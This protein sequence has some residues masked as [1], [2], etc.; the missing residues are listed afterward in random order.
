MIEAG[1]NCV[2]QI[3]A[4][5]A[6]KIKKITWSLSHQLA[7]SYKKSALGPWSLKF[8]GG[9]SKALSIVE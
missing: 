3:G 5:S 7:L 2:D 6:R 9:D 4:S 1:K 8:I